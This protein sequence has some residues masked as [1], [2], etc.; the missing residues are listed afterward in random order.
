MADPL[1]VVTI[2]PGKKIKYGLSMSY[3]RAEDFP[4]S[5]IKSIETKFYVSND[6]D[7]K[8]HYDTENVIVLNEE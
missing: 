8:D 3:S 2:A 5:G 4:M 7:W 6:D 1:F